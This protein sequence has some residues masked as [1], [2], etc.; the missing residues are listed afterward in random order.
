MRSLIIILFCC[1]GT[2]LNAQ[3]IQDTNLVVRFP[4]RQGLLLKTDYRNICHMAYDPG[5]ATVY[6]TAD[7]VFHFEEGLVKKIFDLGDAFAIII[8]NNRKELIVYS[9]L[10]PV[11]L[12]P[13]DRIHKDMYIGRIVKGDAGELNCLDILVFIDKKELKSEELFRYILT[14]I[15]AIQLYNL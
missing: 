9:N 2:L 8:E 13:G 11:N 14:N 1:Y 5:I 15:S 4:V 6:T 10:L 3:C 12:K 7:S